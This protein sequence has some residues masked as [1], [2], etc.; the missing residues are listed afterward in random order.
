MKNKLEPLSSV[1]D[2]HTVQVFRDSSPEIDIEGNAY[3]ISIR[4][5]V[6]PWPLFVNELTKILLTPE[7]K[8]HCIK[9]EDILMPGR[10]DRYPARIIQENEKN[11]IPVGHIT[12]IRSTERIN[13]NY[14]AWYL[15][16]N[17]TQQELAKLLTGTNIKSLNKSKLMSIPIYMPERHVQESISEIQKLYFQKII[18]Q[19]KLAILDEIEVKAVCE[20][21]FSKKEDLHG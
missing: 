11:I 19:K 21:I 18:L 14:L 6:G 15:N 5:I 17:E 10:G 20:N 1:A 7:Q 2:L 13:P 12:V 3:S 9:N 4:D 16:R 8:Q